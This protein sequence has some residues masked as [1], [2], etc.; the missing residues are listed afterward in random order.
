V[1]GEKARPEIADAA[2]GKAGDDLDGLGRPVLL[3]AL[4]LRR[5]AECNGRTFRRLSLEASLAR[6]GE[7][8][9][10]CNAARDHR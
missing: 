2:R 4:G 7:I 8:V 1:I 10:A 5:V 6:I 3:R 9:K